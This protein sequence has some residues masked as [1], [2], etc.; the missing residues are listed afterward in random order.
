MEAA[1]RDVVYSFFEVCYPVEE[2]EKR[3]TLGAWR[4]RRRGSVERVMNTHRD[5]R[6]QAVVRA[7]V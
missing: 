6:T 4:S 1:S 7:S 2:E 3:R 5:L